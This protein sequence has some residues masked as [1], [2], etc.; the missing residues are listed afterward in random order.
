ML[1]ACSDDSDAFYSFREALFLPRVKNAQYVADEI[2]KLHR[3]WR[4][5]KAFQKVADWLCHMDTVAGK[6]REHAPEGFI[7]D[8]FEISRMPRNRRTR[9][10]FVAR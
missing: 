8:T 9:V 10:I 6:Q 5:Y 7:R 1:E 4:V 3:S 2:F